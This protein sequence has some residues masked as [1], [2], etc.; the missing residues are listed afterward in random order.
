MSTSTISLPDGF[1]AGIWTNVN[2][3]F[4]G[5]SP[6]LTLVIGVVL[7]AVVLEIIIGALTK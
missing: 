4:S 1:I 6:W 2:S 7:A 5:L 3:L